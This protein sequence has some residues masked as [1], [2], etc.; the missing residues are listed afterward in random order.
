MGKMTRE[1]WAAVDDAIVQ[2]A[3]EKLESIP[4]LS[5]LLRARYARWRLSLEDRGIDPDAEK[6]KQIRESLRRWAIRRGPIVE[7]R[8]SIREWVHELFSALRGRSLR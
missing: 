8:I 3:R 4:T 6:E 5:D 7:P 1:E 2:V